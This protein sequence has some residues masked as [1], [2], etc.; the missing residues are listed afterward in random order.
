MANNHRYFQ[1]DK[2]IIE[3][4]HASWSPTVGNRYLIK[5]FDTLCF[6]D[7]GLDRLQK[8]VEP[9]EEKEPEH[10][11]EFCVYQQVNGNCYPCSMC[12]KGIERKDMFIYGDAIDLG[13]KGK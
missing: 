13:K 2:F 1:G 12:D 4:G 10:S 7:K 5:G 9:I 6:D 11:C 8:Y 3:I